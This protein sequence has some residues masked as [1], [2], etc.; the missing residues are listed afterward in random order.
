[1]KIYFKGL[2]IF[3]LAVVLCIPAIVNASHRVQFIVGDEVSNCSANDDSLIPADQIPSEYVDNEHARFDGWYKDQYFQIKFEFENERINEDTRLYGR[4]LTKEEPVYTITFDY[5]GG[6]KMGLTKWI[7]KWVGF[8]PSFTEDQL[9]NGMR[10]NEPVV[11]PP[12]GMKLA[13]FEVDGVRKE[14]GSGVELT[15]I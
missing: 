10:D 14:L 5:N 9:I 15:M 13:A 6:T 11:N 3:V 12:A 8:V 2:F 4:W 1:M 7:E